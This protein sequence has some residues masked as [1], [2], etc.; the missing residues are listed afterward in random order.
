MMQDEQSITPW[1]KRMSVTQRIHVPSIEIPRH[2]SDAE[3]RAYPRRPA[4]VDRRSHAA[5]FCPGRH[6][7]WTSQENHPPFQWW[8][9]E[10]A[11]MPPE[12]SYCWIAS[13]INQRIAALGGKGVGERALLDEYA[14]WHKATGHWPGEPPFARGEPW[15]LSVP[16][17]EH[18]T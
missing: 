16:T 7:W 6:D 14:A 13:F 2:P 1:S 8:S 5:D 18:N 4:G 9:A 11:G 17:P 12:P 3:R 10:Q 15:W